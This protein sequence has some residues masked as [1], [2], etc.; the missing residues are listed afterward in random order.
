M[1]SDKVVIY[2]HVVWSTRERLP[3]VTSRIR[4]EL[5]RYIW[6]VCEER[7]CKPHAIGGTEDHVHLLV[8]LSTVIP[9]SELVQ[10]VK[11]GSSRYVTETLLPGEPFGW[12]GGYGVFSVSESEIV[13][14][15]HYIDRQAQHHHTRT[16]N[17][18]NEA[19][20]R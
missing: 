12:Q 16:I 18:G 5:Y 3:L 14:V 1:S 11:G 15:I 8:Q 9:V 17:T 2:I 20:E 4:R 7:S 6:Q 19:R 13:S 10:A